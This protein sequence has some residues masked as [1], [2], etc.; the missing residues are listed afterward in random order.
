MCLFTC[1][2][3]NTCRGPHKCVHISRGQRSYL[4]GIIF[5]KSTP[6][7]WDHF[8]FCLA[9]GVFVLFYRLGAHQ[10]S[11]LGWSESLRDPPVFTSPRTGVTGM[12][13]LCWELNLGSHTSKTSTLLTGLSPQTPKSLHLRVIEPWLEAARE[14][15]KDTGTHRKVRIRW[16]SSSD[17]RSSA[18]LLY[19]M[20]R[21]A[22]LTHI[23]TQ[24]GRMYGIQHGAQLHKEAG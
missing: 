2:Y 5:N 24:G 12:H 16:K 18:H 23:A 15:R 8:L 9:F 11:Q 21:E 14:W 4:V 10:F 19:T 17:P 6:F 3:T 13:H 22:W 7:L 1:K 20:H